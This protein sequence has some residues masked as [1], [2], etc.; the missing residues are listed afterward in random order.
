MAASTSAVISSRA[1]AYSKPAG[2]SCSGVTTPVIPS[3]ST[4]MKT[5]SPWA[6]PGAAP[7]VRSR[8]MAPRPRVERMLIGASGNRRSRVNR[9]G[10]GGRPDPIAIDRLPAD[11][12]LGVRRHRVGGVVIRLAPRSRAARDLDPDP[13][14]MLE[15]VG[16]VI[17]VDPE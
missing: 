3:M 2:P 16:A 10:D 6:E 15:P 8:A 14:T 11:L 9:Q 12:P 17:E 5:L 13:M 7:N 4:E 1:L